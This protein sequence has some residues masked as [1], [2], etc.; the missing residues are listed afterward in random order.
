MTVDDEK[1]TLDK[2]RDNGTAIVACIALIVSITNS[3]FQFF[4]KP[5]KLTVSRLDFKQ[6]GLHDSHNTFT[7]ELAFINN[8][9]R[10]AIIKQVQLDL[11]TGSIEGTRIV[12]WDRFADGKPV[13]PVS[14]KPGEILV[15]KIV[16]DYADH[17]ILRELG[18]T[19]NDKAIIEVGVIVT[20]VD[21]DGEEQE[22]TL[23]GIT[24]N[25]FGQEITTASMKAHLSKTFDE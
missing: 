7:S 3:Y 23:G 18:I 16:F 24:I 14:V 12:V 2:W 1:S 6:H 20:I 22:I 15:K 17:A 13:S 25:V 19:T 21:S 4:H 9:E 8:G 5:Y 10:D 11:K